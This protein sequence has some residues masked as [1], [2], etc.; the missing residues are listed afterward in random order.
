MLPSQHPP[1]LDVPILDVAYEDLV[2][3]QEA[4]TRRMLDFAGLEW[5]DRC[6]RFYE[7]DRVTITASAEQVRRPIYSGSVGRH[8]P[9]EKYLGALKDA[10]G[11]A[12]AGLEIFI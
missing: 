6:M 2:A 10:T 8:K 12:K 1:V 11:G 7:T 5:D 9:Y 4:Q 3:D